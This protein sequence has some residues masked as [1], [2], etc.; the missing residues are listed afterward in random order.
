MY[1]SAKST[2]ELHYRRIHT[3]ICMDAGIDSQAIDHGHECAN[4]SQDFLFGVRSILR[5][6]EDSLKHDV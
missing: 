6:T 2:R 3:R 5:Q 1:L 4:A